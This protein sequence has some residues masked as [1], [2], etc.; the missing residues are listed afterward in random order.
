MLPGTQVFAAGSTSGRETAPLVL[1]GSL[2]FGGATTAPDKSVMQ[3]AAGAGNHGAPIAKGPAPAGTKNAPPSP[4]DHAAAPNAN[5]DDGGGQDGGNQGDGQGDGESQ[6]INNQVNTDTVWN[7]TNVEA[8]DVNG[9]VNV[10]ASATANAFQALT[11]NDTV[12]DNNQYAS[13][14]AVGSDLNAMVTNV[15]G[16]V[17]LGN[18]VACNAADVSTDPAYTVVN[19]KQEC[20]VGD[21]SQATNAFV[22]QVQNDVNVSGA[23]AANVYTEDTNAMYNYVNTNQIN[24][25]AVNS[26]TNVQTYNVG[27]SVNVSSSAV[28]NTAQIVH[29]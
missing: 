15:N 21:P 22:A 27:G 24:Q 11:F 6:I 14:A 13:G 28:G 7:N 3:V 5:A 29:Y 16:S 19:S 2:N 20:A 17:N 25:S 18:T 8:D 9:D 23:V 1:N 4:D 12:V 10:G 26:T